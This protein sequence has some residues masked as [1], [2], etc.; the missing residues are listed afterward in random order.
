MDVQTLPVKARPYQHQ[1]EAFEFACR[2]FGL[3]ED[4]DTADGKKAD[5]VQSLRQGVSQIPIGDKR[6]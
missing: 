5:N 4:G 6:A 1:C 3:L 2:L